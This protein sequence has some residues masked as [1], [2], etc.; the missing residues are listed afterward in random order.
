MY[1]EATSHINHNTAEPSDATFKVAKKRIYRHFSFVLQ[2]WNAYS[3]DPP[4]QGMGIWRKSMQGNFTEPFPPYGRPRE[5]YYQGTYVKRG[6]QMMEVVGG[7]LR[8]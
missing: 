7:N 6:R 8:C 1:K 3:M 2:K 5:P 4:E